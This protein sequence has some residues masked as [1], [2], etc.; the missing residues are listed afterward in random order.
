MSTKALRALVDTAEAAAKNHPL[1]DEAL[2]V[3]AEARSELEAIEKAAPVVYETYAGKHGMGAESVRKR[4]EAFEL[5]H[6]IAEE[7]P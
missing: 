6:S 1:R 4:R 2:A 7:A 3:I 5:M